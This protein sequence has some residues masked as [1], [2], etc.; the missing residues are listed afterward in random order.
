MKQNNSINFPESSKPGKQED[1][2]NYYRQADS[3]PF[4]IR[5]WWLRDYEESRELQWG[6]DVQLKAPLWS[7]YSDPMCDLAGSEYFDEY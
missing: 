2:Q 6:V 7:K 5:A 3:L 4:L 1:L